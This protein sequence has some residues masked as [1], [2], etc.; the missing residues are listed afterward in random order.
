M[1][2]HIRKQNWH[3]GDYIRITY[4]SKSKIIY[5]VNIRWSLSKKKKNNRSEGLHLQRSEYNNTVLNE[6]NSTSV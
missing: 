5:I 4:C 3:K 6:I 1:E 2:V